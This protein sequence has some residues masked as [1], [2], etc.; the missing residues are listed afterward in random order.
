MQKRAACSALCSV[1]LLSQ[2]IS[3][4]VGKGGSGGSGGGGDEFLKL[5]CG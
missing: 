4:A 3:A 5:N 2:A 1:R